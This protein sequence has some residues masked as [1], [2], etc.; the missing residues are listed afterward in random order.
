MTKRRLRPEKSRGP[1]GVV[2]LGYVGLPLA[3]AF[4]KHLPVIGFDIKARRIAAL[5]RGHDETGETTSAE[6]RR[7]NLTFTT[8]PRLLRRCPFVVITVPTPIDDAKEPDL[9]PVRRAS[10]IVGR[11][12]RRGATV[13]LEST[14]YPG[15]TEE[16]VLPILE[17]ASG[18]RL[19][20]GEFSVAYSPERINPG[21]SQHTLE[22]VI[23]VVSGCDAATLERVAA[24]YGLVCKAGVHR[25]PT[26]KTAEAAKVIENIQRDLNIAL[27]NEL[28]L[29]FARLDIETRAVLDAAATKWNFQKFTPGLVGG[30]CIGVDPYYLTHKALEVGH[31]PAVI[32][33]GRAVNDAMAVHVGRMI[34]LAISQS[35]RPLKGARVLMMGLT[36]KENVPDVRNSKVADTIRHLRAQK[37]EV[38]GCDPLLGAAVVRREFGIRN[39]PFARAGCVDAVCI[40]N[41]HRAFDGVTLADLK[42]LMPRQPILVDIKNKFSRRDAE[43]MGFAYFSL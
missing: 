7:R 23:K 38:I 8:D 35:G 27:M 21:D 3:V 33:A 20:R 41:N 26:I 24:Y 10:A 17:R 1:I 22:R 30:H 11:N 28:S 37:V 2:G 32:L 34:A 43:R 4:A 29:I 18:L 19:A 15:V 9:G 6:L 42:R 13:V 40:V 12:L 25:A 36:F 16:V 39:V 5:R 31:H 14:V